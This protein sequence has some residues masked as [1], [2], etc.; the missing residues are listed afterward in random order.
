M[1]KTTDDLRIKEIR[2]LR[3]PQEVIRE[4]PRT[5]A[6]TK[7]VIGTR[8]AQDR[9]HYADHDLVTEKDGTARRYLHRDGTPYPTGA[10]P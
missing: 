8:H 5:D 10:H 9:I 1:L 3:S 2:E 7:T 6:A 4:F